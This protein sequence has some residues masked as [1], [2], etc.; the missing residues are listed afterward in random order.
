LKRRRTRAQSGSFQAVLIT[1][2]QLHIAEHMSAGSSSTAPWASASASG[3]AA[4][5]AAAAAASAAMPPPTASPAPPAAPT[6]SGSGSGGAQSAIL[7][8]AE[9]ANDPNIFT[10]DGWIVFPRS[11]GAADYQPPN[12]VVPPKS[13][14]EVNYFHGASCWRWL[15]ALRQASMLT[16]A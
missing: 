16:R 6:A 8:I 5:P 7:S 11:D 4:S 1:Q 10:H 3:A 15:A 13:D 14:R 2:L 12:V 9:V